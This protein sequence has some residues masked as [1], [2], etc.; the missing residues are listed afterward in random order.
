M[1]SIVQ[2]SRFTGNDLNDCNY[3][4]TFYISSNALNSPGSFYDN[5]QLI[6]SKNQ[7]TAVQLAFSY[8]D[9]S[10]FKMRIGRYIGSEREEW[11]PWK[12][13]KSTD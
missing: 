10:V 9:S 8:K 7:D 13:F 5:G 1:G 12:T 4:S 11:L 2:E 3:N 6:V